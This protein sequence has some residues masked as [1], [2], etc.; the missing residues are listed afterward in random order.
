MHDRS[1]QAT[2]RRRQTQRGFTL[3]ELLIVVAIV[4]V[5]AAV[6][7]PMINQSKND[8]ESAELDAVA[9]QIF[10][11]AQNK[12]TAMVA[13]GTF[14]DFDAGR[15]AAILP[16]GLNENGEYHYAGHTYLA[17]SYLEILPAGAISSNVLTDQYYIEYNAKTGDIYGVFYGKNGFDYAEAVLLRAESH[18]K[19][20]GGV[21]IGYFG[22]AVGAGMEAVRTQTPDFTLVNGEELYV[23]FARIDEG[24]VYTLTVAD[25]TSPQTEPLYFRIDTNDLIGSRIGSEPNVSGAVV[26]L[27]FKEDVDGSLCILLDSLD[28]SADPNFSSRRFKDNFT[29]GNGNALL[30]PGHDLYLSGKAQ[31]AADEEKKILYLESDSVSY[32]TNSLFDSALREK[33]QNE[34]VGVHNFRH[35]QNLDAASGYK[36]TTALFEARLTAR[37]DWKDADARKAT[38][39]YT[40]PDTLTAI[41]NDALLVFDGQG[42]AIENAPLSANQNG[43]S[44]DGTAGLFGV[45]TGRKDSAIKRVRLVDPVLAPAQNAAVT[46]AGLLAGRVD[47]NHA[48]I[49]DCRVFATASGGA[50]NAECAAILPKSV[51]YAGGLIGAMQGGTVTDCFAAMPVIRLLDD[52]PTESR[53]LGGLIGA[54]KAAALE[55]CYANTGLLNCVM[56]GEKDKLGGLIGLADGGKCGACYASGVLDLDGAR[57]SCQLSGFAN[58][59]NN[60]AFTS[61]YTVVTYGESLYA[62]A[63]I[64]PA[65]NGT[66]VNNGAKVYAFADAP[67]GASADGRFYLRTDGVTEFCTDD[68]QTYGEGLSYDA[69]KSES[70][71][72]RFSDARWANADA[73]HTHAYAAAATGLYPFPIPTG[74][75]TSAVTPYPIDHYGD[76]PARQGEKYLAYYEKYKNGQYGFFAGNGVEIDTLQDSADAAVVEDGYAVLCEQTDPAPTLAYVTSAGLRTAALTNSGQ[77]VGATLTADAQAHTYRAWCFPA[78][79]LRASVA[80]KQPATAKDSYFHVFAAGGYRLFANPNFAKYVVNGLDALPGVSYEPTRIVLRTSRQL[81]RLSLPAQNVYWDRAFSQE[82]RIDFVTYPA[83]VTDQ[84]MPQPIGNSAVPFTGI[85]DGNRNV[86]NGLNVV[87]DAASADE[88]CAGMFGDCQGMARLTRIRLQNPSVSGGTAYAGILAG[89]LRAQ[90]PREGSQNFMVSDCYVYAK[91]SVENAFLGDPGFNG[92]CTLTTSAGIVGGLAGSIESSSV[93]DTLVSPTK[94]EMRDGTHGG[95][96]AGKLDGADTVIEQC[97]ANTKLLK[98]DIVGMLGGFA[99]ESTATVRGAYALGAISAK[100]SE[101]AGFI[102]TN[103]G[104]C[105]MCYT[106]CTYNQTETEDLYLTHGYGFSKVATASK[107]QNC[108]Y[109]G[110][111]GLI[112]SDFGETS[113]YGELKALREN[114]ALTTYGRFSRYAGETHRYEQSGGYPFAFLILSDNNV[115]TTN[116]MPHYGD[117]PSA[118]GTYLAYYEQYREADGKSSYG[119][120]TT[121]FNQLDDANGRE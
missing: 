34:S 105:T 99:G 120:Y 9:R 6:A 18:R 119:F 117:W 96:F 28:N 49:T 17:K 112:E 21:G 57:E 94:I 71:R 114:L 98:T 67:K 95:G 2:A 1:V 100:E 108:Y 30:T 66:R 89:R 26:K 41:S 102:H 101:P 12:S 110:T 54:A 103:N 25:A 70:L 116:V 3:I 106:L 44:T 74:T 52:A 72:A 46:H 36:P 51:L 85:F 14:D 81:H 59:Q 50:A 77:L 62:P 35:L 87:V 45:F 121:V 27:P 48:A 53:Y 107:L 15:E 115:L 38:V 104:S 92:A 111:R 8:L 109:W 20:K 33:E 39:G 91:A 11:A 86:I 83:Q 19:T 88:A 90:A 69:M 78:E 97:Y 10:I 113:T 68:G 61:C 73:A 65:N 79:A 23:R 82:R 24:T 13:L 29:D 58:V 43:A 7:I 42:N 56:G 37:L 22:G 40:A 118:G 32:F 76:W 16:D 60:P 64:N 47:G 84:P 55:R 4:V 5:L 80:Q 93:C 31:K 63:F 75:A